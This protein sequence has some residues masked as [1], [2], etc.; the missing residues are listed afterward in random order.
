[1]ALIIRS[2][3]NM[4]AP[5][6]GTPIVTPPSCADDFNRP[7]G[8]LGTTPVGAKP[9]VQ[10]VGIIQIVSNSAEAINAAGST[11]TYW[12]VDSGQPTGRVYLT[13]LTPD[14]HLA[15]R[16][17]ES[18]QGYLF[19]RSTATGKYG[20]SIRTSGQMTSLATVVAQPFLGPEKLSIEVLSNGRMLCKVNDQVVIDHTDTTYNGTRAGIRLYGIGAKADNF[21]VYA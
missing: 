19:G 17:D 12:S 21:A 3:T 15:A 14:A 1:M 5:L 7:D 8:P 10:H 9:W 11:G 18:G 20:L 4:S 6:P 2:K 13:A 16:C